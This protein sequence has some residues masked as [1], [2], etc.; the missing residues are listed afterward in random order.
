[1]QKY[2]VYNI[3]KYVD[4]IRDRRKKVWEIVSVVP[5]IP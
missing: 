2:I 5:P 3:N 4:S 1:M